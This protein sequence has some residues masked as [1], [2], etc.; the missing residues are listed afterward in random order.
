MRAI[1]ALVKS[2]RIDCN[3]T[4]QKVTL[5]CGKKKKRKKKSSNALPYIPALWFADFTRAEPRESEPGFLLDGLRRGAKSL[6]LH[7]ELGLGLELLLSPTAIVPLCL[8]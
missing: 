6:E 5:P 1:I 3:R 2:H 8:I 7:L 4:L